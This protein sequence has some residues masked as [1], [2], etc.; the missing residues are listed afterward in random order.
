MTL[1]LVEYENCQPPHTWWRKLCILTLRLGELRFCLDWQRH[2]CRSCSLVYIIVNI[3]CSITAAPL[4]NV[5]PGSQ[6]PLA[7]LL[8]LVL[9]T[10]GYE[11]ILMWSSGW[12]DSTVSGAGTVIGVTCFTSRRGSCSVTFQAQVSRPSLKC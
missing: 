4:Q 9:L 5:E 8:L 6:P 3:R 2:L 11:V 7:E 1:L 10:P 12:K